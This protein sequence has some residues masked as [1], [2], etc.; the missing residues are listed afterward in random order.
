MDWLGTNYAK[1]YAPNSREIIRRQTLHQFVASALVEHN[2]DDPER[3]VN[4]GYNCYQVSARVLSLLQKYGANEWEGELRT[5]L[6][7]LP[8]LQ[9]QYARARAE[10]DPSDSSRRFCRRAYAGWP[11]RSAQG[12]GRGVLRK[13]DSWR[14]L[15]GDE[16][17]A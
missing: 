1:D 3:S 14:P 9:E 16:R 17:R 12:H 13:V 4:S 5:Y 8:G 7:D 15:A 11:E 6:A 10:A 2:P